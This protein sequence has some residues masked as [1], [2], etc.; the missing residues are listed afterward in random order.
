[1]GTGARVAT[2]A[3][4]SG[5]TVGT[6]M[7]CGARFGAPAGDGGVTAIPAA[8]V[9]DAASPVA[10]GA[11]APVLVEEWAEAS[12]QWMGKPAQPKTPVDDLK[13]LN[14]LRSEL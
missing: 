5:A 13:V 11:A 4:F 1:M 2:G 9:A 14:L 10:G 6:D 12:H 8:A 7:G 3:G